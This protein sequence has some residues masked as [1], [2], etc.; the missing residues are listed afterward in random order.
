MPTVF[1]K[2]STV[3]AGSV[4]VGRPT[5]WGNPFTIGPDGTRTEVVIK[6]D[7][8][9]RNQPDL[10]ERIRTELKG[11]DLVCWCSP[12]ICHADTLL[13]IANGPELCGY[14]GC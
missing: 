14:E 9:I 8:W 1:N 4:Y 12:A 2:R 7:A 11:K 10:I 13:E 5:V 3:P 6:Y